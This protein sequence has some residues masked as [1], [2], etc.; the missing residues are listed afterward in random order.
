MSISG[1]FQNLSQWKAECLLLREI[2][3][4]TGLEESIKWGGPCYTYEGQNVVSIESFKSYF[5]LWFFQGALL[6]DKPGYFI[7][8]EVNKNKAIRQWRFNTMDE[9]LNAPVREYIL[10]SVENFKNGKKIKPNTQKEIIL[11]DV[12]QDTL[13]NDAR[14][15]SQWES[16][17]RSCQ[18]EYAE[19][20]G[21]AKKTETQ[22]NRIQ[23]IIPMILDKKG[24]NDK[25]K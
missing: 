22:L 9:V 3:L 15:L 10:E 4:S 25:Y 7:Q 19:Y 14:L 5:G 23:K 2:V 16:L 6:E 1:Y 12:L 17:S 20:I 24:L 21:Q 8:S 11:P 18:R 13:T